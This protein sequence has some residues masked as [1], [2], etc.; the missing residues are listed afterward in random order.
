M[1]IDASKT[2]WPSETC[3]NAC[4]YTLVL[5]I[6]FLRYDDVGG[7]FCKNIIAHVYVPHVGRF[8]TI[9][10]RLIP[11]EFYY[12]TSIRGGSQRDDLPMFLVASLAS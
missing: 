5:A 1:E 10:S 8:R 6:L 2:H 3:L 9:P 12:I 7:R 11:E 4:L